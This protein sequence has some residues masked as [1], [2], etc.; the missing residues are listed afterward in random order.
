MPAG[1]RTADRRARAGHSTTAESL[2][3]T[4]VVRIRHQQDHHAATQKKYD[5]SAVFVMRTCAQNGLA[6]RQHSRR[7]PAI[8]ATMRLMTAMACIL[9]AGTC[10]AM[11]QPA[12]STNCQGAYVGGFGGALFGHGEIALLNSTATKSTS[13]E[14]AIGGAFAGYDWLYGSWLIGAETD[15]T[16]SA[17]S[18]PAAGAVYLIRLHTDLCRCDAKGTRALDRSQGGAPRRK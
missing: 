9:V 16:R 1:I 6:F 3:L 11:A 18:S 12:P 14:K 10:G 5:G 15:W 2:L 13:S 17:S 7:N 4:T 8:G